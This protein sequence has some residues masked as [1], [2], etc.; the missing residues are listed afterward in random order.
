MRDLGRDEYNRVKYI[1]VTGAT[2]IQCPLGTAKLP[3][4][5]VEAARSDQVVQFTYKKR[6]RKG[7]STLLTKNG[8]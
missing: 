6:E 3:T 8:K 1:V 2:L 4:E 7:V 5:V